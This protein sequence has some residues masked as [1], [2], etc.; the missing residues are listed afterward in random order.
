VAYL[1]PPEGEAPVH[2]AGD[3]LI[4]DLEDGETV[5]YARGV[6]QVYGWS[7]DSSR[8]AFLDQSSVPQ[9][10]IGELGDAPVPVH[11]DPETVSI[12]V[13]WLDSSRFLYTAI[14]TQGRTLYLAEIGQPSIVVAAVPGRSL[15][16]DVCLCGGL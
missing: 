13:R 3:L 11:G 10:R 12:D 16:Y 8:L 9:A 15:L 6:S 2:G 1:A 14:T 4:A 7:P 5:T